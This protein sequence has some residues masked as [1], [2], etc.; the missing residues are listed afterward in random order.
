MSLPDGICVVDHPLLKARVT[1]LR[2]LETP[3]DLFRRTLH[4][5]TALLAFEATRRLRTSGQHVETPLESYEGYRLADPVVVVPILRA[6]LGMAEA[7]LRILPEARIGHIGMAR[8]EKTF[9]PE[10]Y[11]FNAPPDLAKS[12]V[13]LVDPMLATGQSAADA[14]SELKRRG[15]CHLTLVSVIGAVPGALHFRQSHPDVPVFLAALD[16]ELNDQAYIVPGLG[17]AGDRYF[18]T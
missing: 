8:D 7:M 10:A 5:I 1:V 14:A 18:G 4:E 2:D 16:P 6:G 15:A 12:S 9:L 13:F 11:Y 17:D 3:R